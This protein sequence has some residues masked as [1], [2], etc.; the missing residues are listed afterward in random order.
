MHS[1]K[2]KPWEGA[3]TLSTT[4]LRI[5][6]LGIMAFNI[7]IIGIMTLSITKMN[8][9]DAQHKYTPTTTLRINETQH[10]LTKHKDTQNDET[11]HTGTPYSNIGCWH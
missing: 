4:A 5:T 8:H 7:T 11:K 2:D 3:T 6:T 10:N 1:R 9:E